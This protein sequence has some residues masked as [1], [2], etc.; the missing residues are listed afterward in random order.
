MLTR[1]LLRTLGIVAVATVAGFTSACSSSDTT[2]TRYADPVT[3]TSRPA[4][5]PAG[6]Q[7]AQP[8]ATVPG[9]PTAPEA[10]QMPVGDGLQASE[11]GLT[12]TPSTTALS[13]AE[14]SFS[15]RIIGIDGKAFT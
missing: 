1:P 7:S 11:V 9:A 8:S 3:H 15:F 14:T 13:P 6:Q 12:L 5:A 10:P 2:P 4:S